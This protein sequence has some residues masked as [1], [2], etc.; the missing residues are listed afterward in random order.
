MDQTE[1][2]KLLLEAVDGTPK[3][4]EP[5]KGYAN[6]P[7]EQTL[8]SSTQQNFGDDLHKKKSFQ[9]PSRDGDNP[10]ASKKMEEYK[11]AEERLT[12]EFE[13]MKL[14]ESAWSKQLKWDT[15]RE[16]AELM[17]GAIEEVSNLLDVI[18]NEQFNMALQLMWDG[19]HDGA[20]DEI[21]QH[22]ATRDGGEPRDWQA[23]AEDLADS[24]L[25]ISTDLNERP[26]PALES[27]GEI[28]H[29]L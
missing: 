15:R 6:T 2:M 25:H 23:T 9:H 8:D 21:M 28:N 20:V 19:D 22:Y 14:N 13:Q 1:T 5:K 26:L 10:R 11:L 17:R 12:K 3:V 24:F 29:T 7:D 16:L 18:S 4:D 27:T